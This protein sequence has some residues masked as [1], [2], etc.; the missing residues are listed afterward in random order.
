MNLFLIKIGRDFDN[1]VCL[2]DFSVSRHHAEIEQI[3]DK[4]II[5]DLGSKN[6]TYVNQQHL[7]EGPITDK[8][9]ILI[10]EITLV[11]NLIDSEKP[12]GLEDYLLHLEDKFVHQEVVEK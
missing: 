4:Y 9:E 7:L 5:R 2:D 10:G 3:D 12:S 1:D 11:F 8:D 6:G